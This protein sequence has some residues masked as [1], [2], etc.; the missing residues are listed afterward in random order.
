MEHSGR[1]EA[2]W[3]RVSCVG[4][5][6][7]VTRRSFLSIEGQDVNAGRAQACAAISTTNDITSSGVVAAPGEDLGLYLLVHLSFELRTLLGLTRVQ[8]LR[9]FFVP[10]LKYKREQL[11]GV[12]DTEHIHQA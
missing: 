7:A 1:H 8:L 6:S 4:R 2:L 10:Q 5:L 3:T 12:Q 9:V 11:E